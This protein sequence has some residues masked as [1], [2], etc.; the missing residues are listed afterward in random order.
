MAAL[1]ASQRH[2]ASHVQTCA[3]PSERHA[4]H[5]ISLEIVTCDAGSGLPSVVVTRACVP[6]WGHLPQ[7]Y[8][9]P[10]AVID[11]RTPCRCQRCEATK[12][13]ESIAHS[14]QWGTVATPGNLNQPAQPTGLT[15]L[16]AAVAYKQPARVMR[17]VFS[18]APHGQPYGIGKGDLCGVLRAQPAD[19]EAVLGVGDPH[20]AVAAVETRTAR[21]AAALRARLLKNVEAGSPAH[22]R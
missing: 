1:E 20:R 19:I 2:T 5:K 15:L 10:L 8:A 18:G 11:R 16:D 6:W 7:T 9:Q 14:R 21:R 17:Y 3:H 12:A 4:R 13:N 22:G